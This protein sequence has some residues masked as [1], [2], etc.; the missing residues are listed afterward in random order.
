MTKGDSV[1]FGKLISLA[2]G[3]EKMKLYTGWFFAALTGATLPTF[4]FFIGPVFDSFGG[5]NDLDETRSKVH[6]VCLIMLGLA[7]FIFITSFF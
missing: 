4:F 7:V 6:E 2:D 3:S 1:R 5:D